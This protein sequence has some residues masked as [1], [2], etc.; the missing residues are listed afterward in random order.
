MSDVYEVCTAEDVA[1]YLNEPPQPGSMLVHHVQWSVFTVATEENGKWSLPSYGW[2]LLGILELT[3]EQKNNVV[4]PWEDDEV[5][6]V[7]LRHEGEQRV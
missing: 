5:T 4:G 2:C 1:S 7:Y 6:L 3:E